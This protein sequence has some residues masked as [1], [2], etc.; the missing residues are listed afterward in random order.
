MGRLIQFVKRGVG[1]K[2]H[3]AAVH[4][5]DQVKAPDEPQLAAAEA[6][7]GAETALKEMTR[8]SFFCV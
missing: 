8:D 7:P 3:T 2:R 6:P 5:P 4:Y 1:E